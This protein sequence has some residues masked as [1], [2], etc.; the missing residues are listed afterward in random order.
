MSST[1]NKELLLYNVLTAVYT[2]ALF[3]LLYEYEIADDEY[4]SI[5]TLIRRCD[6]IVTAAPVIKQWYNSSVM[7]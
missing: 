5:L 7:L 2:H 6:R 1:N 3:H 4:R